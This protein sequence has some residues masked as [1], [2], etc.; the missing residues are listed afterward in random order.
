MITLSLR[1]VAAIG[2]A[3][4]AGFAGPPAGRPCRPAP[5]EIAAGR[6]ATPAPAADGPGDYP[7]ERPALPAAALAA[8]AARGFAAGNGYLTGQLVDRSA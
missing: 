5:Y 1:I 6:G 7:P 8:A 4:R 2:D 3:P